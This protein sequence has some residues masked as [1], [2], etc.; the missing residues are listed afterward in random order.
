[1]HTFLLWNLLLG[2]PPA[3][4]LDDWETARVL[5][6]LHGKPIFAIVH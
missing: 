5:G 6:R 1:M 3:V 4:W 2:T